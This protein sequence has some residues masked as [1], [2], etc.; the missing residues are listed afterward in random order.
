MEAVLT[1]RERIHGINEELQRPGLTP[2]RVRAM[3]MEVTGLEG[4]CRE[5]QLVWDQA[6]RRVLLKCLETE[7]VAAKATVKAQATDDYQKA[8]EVKAYGDMA[9]STKQSC[10]VYLRSLDEEMRLAR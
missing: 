6:Y 3:L 5:Q 10:K 4:Y 7:N 8:C 9:E 2:D 1:I